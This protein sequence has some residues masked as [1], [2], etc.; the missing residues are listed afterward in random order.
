MND[1]GVAP[2]KNLFE[3]LNLKQIYLETP[4]YYGKFLHPIN[5]YKQFV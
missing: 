4:T 2:N 5:S 1:K 3:N